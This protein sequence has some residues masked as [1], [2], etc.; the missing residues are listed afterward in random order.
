MEG[1]LPSRILGIVL[2]WASIRFDKLTNRFD[3]LTNRFDNRLVYF[4]KLSNRRLVSLSN[5]SNHSNRRSLVSILCRSPPVVELCY[6]EGPC[7][8]PSRTIQ[9]MRHWQSAA[10]IPRMSRLCGDEP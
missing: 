5:Q 10:T 6:S 1:N 4:D 7:V 8:K 3:K 2:E 9:E